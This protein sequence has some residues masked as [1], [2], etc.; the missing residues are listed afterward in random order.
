MTLFQKWCDHLWLYFNYALG[1]LMLCV[2]VWNWNDWGM[3]QKLICMLAIAIPIHNFEEY[4]Y[5]AGFFFMNNIS[6]FSKNP[7]LY[8]QNTISTM[9]TNTGAEL[10]IVALTFAA[11]HIGL[12]LVV[13]VIMF[14]YAETF[15]H[16]L[17][18]II[19]WVRYRPVAKKSIYAPGLITCLFVFC[20]LSTAALRWF[21]MQPFATSDILMGI[22]LVAI[23]MVCFIG[24]PF[25]FV[26]KFHPE[27]YAMSGGLGYFKK[28]EEELAGTKDE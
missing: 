8:P 28:Y 21:T 17:D 26:F 6:A 22:G 10:F 11:P 27:R 23:V 16:V 9:V 20:P 13:M 15:V 24:I 1:A 4:S 7:M 12:P 14:G 2:L 3:A 25:G 18:G 19:M 5:P